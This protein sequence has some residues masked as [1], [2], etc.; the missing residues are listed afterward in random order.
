MGAAHSTTISGKPV[1]RTHFCAGWGGDK[2]SPCMSNIWYAMLK[3]L[4]PFMY[5]FVSYFV[6]FFVRGGGGIQQL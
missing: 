3:V 1:D 6:Y 4:R 2:I 5:I